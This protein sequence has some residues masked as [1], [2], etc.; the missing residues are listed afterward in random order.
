MSRSPRA[1]HQNATDWVHALERV[2]MIAFPRSASARSVWHEQARACIARFL[3]R[4]GSILFRGFDVDEHAQQRLVAALGG[5]ALPIPAIA[6][7]GH[8]GGGMA[9]VHCAMQAA[10]SSLVDLRELYRAL[11]GATRARLVD[12]GLLY[13][14]RLGRDRW[15]QLFVDGEAVADWCAATDAS[16]EWLRDGSLRLALR[17]RSVAR[18]LATGALCW[19]ARTLRFA[20]ADPH[21]GRELRHADGSAIAPQLRVDLERA[22]SCVRTVIAWEPGD[23]LVVDRTLTSCADQREWEDTPDLSCS[24]LSVSTP[25]G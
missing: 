18:Q 7:W 4:R 2:P 3:P 11:P 12:R 1:E 20:S 16:Y 5:S 6:P 22:L 23:L 9:L 14:Q 15:P 25:S 10:P 24:W 17:E 13:V 19:S 8:D 21:S